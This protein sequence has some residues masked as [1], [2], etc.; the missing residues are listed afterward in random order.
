MPYNI[1]LDHTK[2]DKRKSQREDEGEV[3]R[4][5]GSDL[6]GAKQELFNH[7]TVSR[8]DTSCA[9][10]LGSA[11]TLFEAGGR[12]WHEKLQIKGGRIYEERVLGGYE[13][14]RRRSN[15]PP[16]ESWH[17]PH[18]NSGSRLFEKYERRQAADGVPRRDMKQKAAER[19]ENNEQEL[20]QS[21]GELSP[22]NST[23]NVLE[24]EDLLATIKQLRSENAELKRQKNCENREIL[25]KCFHCV[26]GKYYLEEP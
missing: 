3:E 19:I 26:D 10:N 11:R 2:D 8:D 12:N 20:E 1:I 4:F 17:T 13:D 6:E 9:A 15:S 23:S 14:R 25:W 22:P 5:N 21:D 7:S 18:H 16:G 24:R